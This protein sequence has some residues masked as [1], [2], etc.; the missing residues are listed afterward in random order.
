M[1]KL[2]FAFCLLFASSC[3]TSELMYS[4]NQVTFESAER[5]AE[6]LIMTQHKAW[7]PDDFFIT[8]DYLAWD[9][10]N[11]STGSFAGAASNGFVG[12]STSSTT[13]RASNRV[14]F[15]DIEQVKLLSWKRK[16]KQWYV[17]SLTGRDGK[18]LIHALRTVSLVEAE[19]FTDAMNEIVRHQNHNAP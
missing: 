13:R 15:E 10:G 2:I 1:R 11:V 19:K 4:P 16:A 14:Y 12:G 6:K 5:T 18:L 9:F 7:R 3:G 17:V 8:E